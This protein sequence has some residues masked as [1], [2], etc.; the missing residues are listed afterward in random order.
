M[1][2]NMI[3]VDGK[4]GV[5]RAKR[6][7]VTAVTRDKEYDLT[8]G[9]S[10]SRM[11]YFSANPNSEAEVVTVTLSPQCKAKQKIFDY[12][13]ATL[14]I[15]GRGSQGNILTK[16]P[17]RKIQFKEKG[18]STLGGR[19][20]YYDDVLGRL[21]VD[22]RGK[23]IGNFNVD[24]HILVIFKDGNYELTG[25]ELTNRYDAEQVLVI[26]KWNPKRVVTAVYQDGKT[27]LYYAKRF[28]IE[29]ST[30]GKK[31]NFISETKGSRLVMATTR[32]DSEIEVKFGKKKDA[33]TVFYQLDEY[34]DVR[35]WKAV[36]NKLTEA[37]I[38]SIELVAIEEEEPDLE[39]EVSKGTAD[40]TQKLKAI[41]PMQDPVVA[42]EIKELKKIIRPATDLKMPSEEKK[43][44]EPKSKDTA[45]LKLF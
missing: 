41:S 13:F 32:P 38:I 23:Y 33:E 26:E 25:F 27:K 35:G 36:G 6:F 12:D 31:F 28:T 10:G 18:A 5:A 34:V 39:E 8:T 14:D 19:D 29:T 37:D 15:K 40:V 43:P 21:N 2:Y 16:Y 42:E 17:V 11:L 45:Q 30:V 7:A 44:E 4:T 9:T 22:K 3:Y 1:I 20:I 24:D